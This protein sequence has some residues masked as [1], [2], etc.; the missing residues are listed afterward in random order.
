[1]RERTTGGFANVA[2]V[3][4]GRA[5]SRLVP[6]AALAGIAAVGIGIG[7]EARAH[8][9]SCVQPKGP[10]ASA[11]EAT[12]V[13]EGR[14]FGVHRE[15]TKARFSFEVSRVFKGEIGPTVDVQSAS[16]S[17]MCGRGY[18]AGVLYLVY[19]RASPDGVLVDSM[20]TR[21]RAS[22][23]AAEDFSE[24][25]AG[26]PPPRPDAAGAP[27]VSVEAP[28]IETGPPPPAP[29]KRGCSIDG[30]RPVPS[31]TLLLLLLAPRRPTRTP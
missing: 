3:K 1:M 20:C 2:G 5:H 19:A 31:F 25:G 21:T 28:R 4:A 23:S 12:A 22:V 8:A 26:T 15:G 6:L 13:F 14:T 30:P 11:A 17:S 18:E 10:R 24:L 7:L 27:R 9:C 16:Q 29:G